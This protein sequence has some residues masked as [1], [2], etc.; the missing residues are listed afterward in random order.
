MA[1]LLGIAGCAIAVALLAGCAG[2]SPSGECEE[3]VDRRPPA[4]AAA[5]SVA[6]WLDPNDPALAEKA[7]RC[8]MLR[9]ALADTTH[10]WLWLEVD[11]PP[12]RSVRVSGPG[13]LAFDLVDG[14]A[15]AEVRDAGLFVA[16]DVAANAFLNSST[17][18]ITIRPGHGAA[19]KGCVRLLARLPAVDTSRTVVRAVRPVPKLWTLK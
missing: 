6:G 10:A 14:A 16:L 18:P 8:H 12:G 13:S 4:V 1:R 7:A 15:V 19:G 2:T 9:T 17:G 3:A 5:P 11:L